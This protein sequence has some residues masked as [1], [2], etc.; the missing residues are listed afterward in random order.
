MEIDSSTS[1]LLE[2]SE[3]PYELAIPHLAEV[4]IFSR[5]QPND[6]AAVAIDQNEC[7]VVTNT[8]WFHRSI[9]TPDWEN[10]VLSTLKYL[11]VN[12]VY[13]HGFSS[14]ITRV[15]LKNQSYSRINIQEVNLFYELKYPCRRCQSRTCAFTKAFL[16]WKRQTAREQCNLEH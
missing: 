11:E 15:A 4:K 8:L 9:H 13:V 16:L 5:R 14:K 3:W 10:D 1:I 7:V 6:F 2:T 12:D